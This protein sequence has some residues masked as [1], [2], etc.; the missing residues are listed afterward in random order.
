MPGKGEFGAPVTDLCTKN[1]Y[2]RREW[3]SKVPKELSIYGI[4]WYI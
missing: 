4:G 3:T 1:V 2:F